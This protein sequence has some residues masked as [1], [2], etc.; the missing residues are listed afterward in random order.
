MVETYFPYHFARCEHGQTR[1]PR[2]VN[3]ITGRIAYIHGVLMAR[4]SFKLRLN[5][6]VDECRKVISHSGGAGLFPLRLHH[7]TNSGVPSG[8]V[9]NILIR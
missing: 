5:E 8:K 4:S 7:H 6:Q 9:I 1:Q 2:V 3:Q